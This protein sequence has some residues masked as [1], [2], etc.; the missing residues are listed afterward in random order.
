MCSAIVLRYPSFDLWR[1]KFWVWIGRVPVPAPSAAE[2][3]SATLHAAL[4]HLTQV[5]GRKVDLEGALVTKCFHANIALDT[6]LACCGAD[7]GNS[8]VFR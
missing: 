1:V 8:N 3:H 5:N 7:I 2:H 4:M 6:F